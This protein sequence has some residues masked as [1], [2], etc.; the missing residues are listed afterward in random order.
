MTTKGAKNLNTNLDSLRKRREEAEKRFERAKND[1]KKIASQL[2]AAER[3]ERTHK[4]IQL[5][6]LCQM[7]LGSDVDA[8][9]LTG[10]LIKNKA[11]FLSG[12]LEIKLL[13]DTYISEKEEERRKNNL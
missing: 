6:G 13:G 3:R 12:D 10:I 9:L 1:Y 2:T 8:G 7:V 5:G 4:L 11:V